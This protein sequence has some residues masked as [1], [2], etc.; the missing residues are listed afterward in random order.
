MFVMLYFF[1][2]YGTEII[3]Y[4]IITG[5]VTSC[6]R[7]SSPLWSKRASIK[8]GDLDIAIVGH[9]LNRMPNTMLGYA[10]PADNSPDQDP[11]HGYRS[12]SRP[13]TE[14]RCAPPAMHFRQYGVF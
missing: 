12:N 10:R 4:S 9:P 14:M 1:G 5:Q 13:N 8:S 7:P 6:F 3:K 11:S 2:Q